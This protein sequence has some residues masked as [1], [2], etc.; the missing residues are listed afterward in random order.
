MKTEEM[1]EKAMKSLKENGMDPI[2][3]KTKEEAVREVEK[4]L[5]KGAVISC[6]G[7]VTLA[8]SGISDL[9]RNGDYL[10][11]DREKMPREEVYAKT[12]SADVFLTSA[13]AVT[14]SGELYNV[15]GNGNRVAAIVYGPKKVIVVVGVNKLTEDIPSAV[16]RV[17]RIAAPKN[18]VRLHTGTPCE[19]TGH[20]CALGEK[21]M[22]AGC[23]SEN[24]LCRHY[25]VTGK[26]KEGRVR[27]ILVEEEL[28]Y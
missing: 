6:G 28:G 23:A 14:L 17:R 20:C 11:L 25:L 5:W 10:F 16:E 22:T 15:D 21:D 26:Q 1:I 24:R 2:L 8:E 13:N 7:S 4:L 18:A 12:F 9:M 27:V 3:A 19:K